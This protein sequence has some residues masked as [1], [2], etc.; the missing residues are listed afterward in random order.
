MVRLRACVRVPLQVRMSGASAG[1]LAIATYNCGLDVGQ[2][3]SA[4][5]SLAADCRAKGTRNRLGPVVREFLHAYLP[6][7][8]HERC[9]GVCNI[10]VT[11]VYPGFAPEVVRRCMRA[12]MDGWVVGWTV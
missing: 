5:L 3:T 4:L 6:D 8:A 7:D 9:R 12:C 2:A 11:R 1:S 10:H